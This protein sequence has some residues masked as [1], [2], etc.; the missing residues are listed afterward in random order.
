MPD[1]S[2][3]FLIRSS[4]GCWNVMRGRQLLAGRSDLFDALTLLWYFMRLHRG[5]AAVPTHLRP[6]AD[7]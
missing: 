2:Q 1:T 7:R 3:H 5:E 6:G 4:Y